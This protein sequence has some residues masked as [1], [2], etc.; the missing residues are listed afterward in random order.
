MDNMPKYAG[1]NLGANY[2]TNE[3]I[4]SF[5]TRSASDK[6]KYYRQTDGKGPYEYVDLMNV[7]YS[8]CRFS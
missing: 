3:F 6:G 2:I 4:V 8:Y 7:F 1:S 5:I